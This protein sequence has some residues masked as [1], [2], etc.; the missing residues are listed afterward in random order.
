MVSVDADPAAPGGVRPGHEGLLLVAVAAIV[1]VADQ[2]TKWW[3]LQALTD[4]VIPVVWTLQFNLAF[5]RGSAFGLNERFAPYLAV[6]ALVVVA[7][8]VGTGQHRRGRGMAV[9]LGLILGGAIGNLIDRVFRAGEGFLG[10]AVVDFIDL[11]WWPIF[12]VADAA[13]VVGG[14]LLVASG[15]RPEPAPPD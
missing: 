11:Q 13:I 2:L 4:R 10:G 5:N 12:N 15:L 3:A 9:A 8:L 14:L 1:V 6:V 7:V